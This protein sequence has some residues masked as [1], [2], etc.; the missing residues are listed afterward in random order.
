MDYTVWVCSL[1][2]ALWIGDNDRV[3]LATESCKDCKGVGL[4][5]WLGRKWSVRILMGLHD[6]GCKHLALDFN[7]RC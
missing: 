2:K 7:P 5:F 1:L 3:A 4:S 6:P